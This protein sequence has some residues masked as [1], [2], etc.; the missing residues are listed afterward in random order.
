MRKEE[1]FRE[2]T[3]VREDQGGC[4]GHK[5]VLSSTSPTEED[6]VTLAGRQVVPGV[7][8]K[9]SPKQEAALE[10]AYMF[11]CYGKDPK[12]QGLKDIANWVLK[13]KGTV[14]QVE[15]W[16]EARRARGARG[17][18]VEVKEEEV[19]EEEV[20]KVPKKKVKKVKKVKGKKEKKVEEVNV[21]EVKVEDM[22]EEE[23]IVEETVVEEVLEEETL[24]KVEEGMAEEVIVEEWFEAA[25]EVEVLEEGLVEKKLGE[26]VEARS[27]SF[28][29][30][31]ASTPSPSL[32]PTSPSTS[33]W[34]PW[35]GSCE[36]TAASEWSG[37]ATTHL[38]SVGV[39][40]PALVTPSREEVR[41]TGRRV[42]RRL[43]RLLTFQATLEKEKGLPPSRWQRRLEFGGEGEATY[44]S[45]PVSRRRRGRRRVGLGGAEASSPQLRRQRSRVEEDWCTPSPH[46]PRH[47][48]LEASRD[49]SSLLHSSLSP[50]GWGVGG[51]RGFCYGC[52][53]WGNMVPIV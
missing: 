15:A 24:V 32:P 23:G 10:K 8:M 45:T 16:F 26:E 12:E 5:V 4:G 41:S 1:E 34:R 37:E 39:T 40:P 20:K 22:K 30:R 9:L 31:Q 51:H 25:E 48:G 3:L 53:T 21:P 44:P 47:G 19:T 46:L 13:P 18:E 49:N 11:G 52:Q 35:E 7:I 33:F 29:L 14:E 42:G 27:N 38:S 36:A 2:V 6:E 50:G 28:S 17:E 43:R